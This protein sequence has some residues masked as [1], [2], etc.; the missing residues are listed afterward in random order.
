MIK[1]GYTVWKFQDFSV[2]LILRE[3]NFGVSRS[4]KTAIFVF[5]EALNFEFLK[6]FAISEG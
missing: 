2:T 5:L 3:I 4:S 1:K 6:I